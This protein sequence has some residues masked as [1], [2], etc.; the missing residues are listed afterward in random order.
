MPQMTANKT[1]R[2]AGLMTGD[3]TLLL[4]GFT[5]LSITIARADAN[6]FRSGARF[7]APVKRPL[8]RPSP[9]PGRMPGGSVKAMFPSIG[10]KRP[11]PGDYDPIVKNVNRV[12]KV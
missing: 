8:A 11:D 9:A 10:A 1:D 12:K 6:R 4:S 2:V 5:D 3:L 7:A